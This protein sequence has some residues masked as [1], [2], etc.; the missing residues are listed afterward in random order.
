MHDSDRQG[1]DA[2][3]LEEVDI[4]GDLLVRPHRPPDYEAENRALLDLA[5]VMTESPHNILQRLVETALA[6]CR[7]DTAGISLIETHDGEP[8]FRWEALAGVYAA[9]RNNT[10]PRNASP[11][12]TT[13]DRNNTQ[14]MYLPERVFPALRGE[15][16]VVEALLVPFHVGGIPIGTVWVVAHDE[17]RKFDREDE[18]VVLNLAQFASAAWQLLRTTTAA[19]AAGLAQRERTLELARTNEVLQTEI[20][21]RKRADEEIRK[22]NAELERRVL[23]RTRQLVEANRA[24][25]GQADELIRTNEELERF[26]YVSAHDLQEP[27]R[28]VISYAQLLARRYTGRLDS[29]ADE[30]IYYMV[31]EASRMSQLIRDV[32]LYSRLS[33]REK[34]PAPVDCAVIF[35]QIQR[36][37]EEQIKA[38]QATITHSALP[39][40]LGDSTQIGQ[41]FQNLLANALK[42]KHAEPCLIHVSAVRNGD[43]WFFSIQDNGIGIEPLYADQI[44]GV[45]KRLH[46]REEYP[47]SGI[48]LA[49]CKKVIEGHGG[50]IWVES[51]LGKGACFYFTL[52]SV[53]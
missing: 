22:L 16:P 2:V 53:D 28:G 35:D 20:L 40:V 25:A 18:R 42:F 24:L 30:F 11:C 43:R 3:T 5:G 39:T 50:R 48:G 49:I 23:E 6:L 4:K 27:L 17:H 8:V 38:A 14:L 51:Q 45:F 33:T 26:A 21:E 36:S 7:A 1:T 34:K 52:P 9:H 31:S 46:G 41:V 37:L 47:G 15:P 32:L 44:F 19:E 29:E 13:I 10:M 12:G